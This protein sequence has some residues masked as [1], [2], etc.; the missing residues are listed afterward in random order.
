MQYASF[1]T[2]FLA[3]LLDF[4]I[5]YVIS[6]IFDLFL[7]FARIFGDSSDASFIGTSFL[8]NI[9]VSWLYTALYESSEKQATLGKQALGIVVTDLANDRI[10]F[11]RATGRYFASFLSVLTLFIGYFMAAFTEKKQTLH[12][13]IASTLVVKK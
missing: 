8:L 13:L 11:A 4:I 3:F 1:G 6:E 12:D 7:S 5:L 10:S 9:V 2:R